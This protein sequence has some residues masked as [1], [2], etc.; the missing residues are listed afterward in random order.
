MKISNTTTQQS[1]MNT[2]ISLATN[3]DEQRLLCNLDYALSSITSDKWN[4]LRPE[5]RKS[6]L[7]QI[8]QFQRSV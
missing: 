5:Q 7:K 8:L 1:I 2:A 4:M 6:Y 3:R